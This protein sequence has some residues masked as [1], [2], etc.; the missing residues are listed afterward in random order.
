MTELSADVGNGEGT[1]SASIG[2]Y[3]DDSFQDP[4]LHSSGTD[5]S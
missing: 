2:L 4:V 5:L 3:H 1:F